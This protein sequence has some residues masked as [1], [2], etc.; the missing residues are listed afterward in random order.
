MSL[1]CPIS[2]VFITETEL[3]RKNSK[4]FWKVPYPVSYPSN[5]LIS[6]GDESGETLNGSGPNW[7]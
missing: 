4:V 3:F 2:F 6:Y 1:K 7:A 5:G